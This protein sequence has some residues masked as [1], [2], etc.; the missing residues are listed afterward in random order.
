MTNT[1]YK[2]KEISTIFFPRHSNM[3]FP[4]INIHSLRVTSE[5][6]AVIKTNLGIL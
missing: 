5:Q 1:V 6:F 2:L 3:Q 4:V